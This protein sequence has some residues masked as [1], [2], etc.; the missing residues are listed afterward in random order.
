MPTY[1]A[2]LTALALTGFAA[3]EFVLGMLPMM[4]I[5]VL[6]G[7][8]FLYRGRVPVKAEGPKSSNKANDFKEFKHTDK[9][10]A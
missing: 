1:A 4:I 3:G 8:F 9:L 5:L 2:I 6:I 7:C 10:S